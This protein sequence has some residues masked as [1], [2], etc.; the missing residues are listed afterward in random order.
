MKITDYQV[1]G[2]VVYWQGNLGGQMVGL[3]QVDLW[4][5][6]EIGVFLMMA[7][8]I[9]LFVC[10]SW[11]GREGK[12]LCFRKQKVWGALW[13][14]A[15]HSPSLSLLPLSPCTMWLCL[16]RA[17]EIRLTSLSWA[18]WSEFRVKQVL[19]FKVAWELGQ[20]YLSLS[21][22]LCLSC[23]P[24]WHVVP[25]ILAPSCLPL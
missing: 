21:R 5:W 18:G 2:F 6:N 20:A 13:D 3:N 12:N 8:L 15:L 19:D 10:L 4:G 25:K 11:V 23:V 14:E 9:C 22:T 24:V 16:R 1:G 17:A 7:C